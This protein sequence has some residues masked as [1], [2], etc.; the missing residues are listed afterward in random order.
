MT[1]TIAKQNAMPE[2]QIVVGGFTKKHIEDK[3]AVIVIGNKKRWGMIIGYRK[4]EEGN[5]DELAI[6]LG[7]NTVVA[8]KACLVR[9]LKKDVYGYS[10]D[11]IR[12]AEL[13]ARPRKIKMCRKAKG[14]R[15]KY[16]KKKIL[17]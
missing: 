14:R 4:D 9:I 2:K 17:F 10:E 6:K 7:R 5:L 12:V 8:R 13:D 16:F 1:E 11:G 15:K 3:I